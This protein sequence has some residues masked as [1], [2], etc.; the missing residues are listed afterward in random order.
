MKHFGA[1]LD[2]IAEAAG[3]VVM[4]YTEVSEP[5]TAWYIPRTSVDSWVEKNALLRQALHDHNCDPARPVRVG[6]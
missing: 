2:L 3:V 6:S 1:R 5:L 4:K